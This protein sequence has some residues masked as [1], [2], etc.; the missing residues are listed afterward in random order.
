MTKSIRITATTALAAGMIVLASCSGGGGG[1]DATPDATDAAGGTIT[2]AGQV[3]EQSVWEPLI[4]AFEEANPGYTVNATFTPN[5]AYPQLIQTQFQSG[6]AADVIQVTPGS[7]G[8]LAGL[9]LADADRLAT[10]DDQPW[11]GEVPDS[12]K[13]LIS[14]DDHTYILPTAIAPFFVLYN[15]AIFEQV[16]ADVPTSFDDLLEVCGAIADAGITPIGLAGA[17]FSNVNITLQTL[18]ASVVDGPDP[19]WTDDR[20]AGDTTFADSS[21]WQKVL[22]DFVD[23]NEAG[24]YSPDAAGVA[25]PVHLQQF[26]AGQAAMVVVPAQAIAQVTANASPDLEMSTFVFPGTSEAKTWLPSVAGIGLAVNAEAKDMAAANKFIEY[27]G[28][29][30]ARLMY[31]DATGGIAW[32]AGDNGEDVVPEILQPLGD[33][34]S[35]DHAIA[36]TYLLWPGPG[37]AQQLA[38]S[39]QGLL[40]GQLTI[41][42]VLAATDKAWDDVA[43]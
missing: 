35:S 38:T 42:D 17:S 31:S 21:G 32:A 12:Q 23:L 43:K 11:V 13:P 37:V 4:A 15:P 28:S 16:G 24:C 14:R 20:Y 26:G 18:A 39:A 27:L 2:F 3:Q 36:P 22:E 29:P 10:L 6:Q 9:T 33:I 7:G 19:G 5:D 41:D 30:E 8:G 1:N 40:T 34:V 25:A